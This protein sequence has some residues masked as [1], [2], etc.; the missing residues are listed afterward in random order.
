MRKLAVKL[1]FFVFIVPTYASEAFDDCLL[2]KIKDL[3]NNQTKEEIRTECNRLVKVEAESKQTPE[4]QVVVTTNAISK[5]IKREVEAENNR[6]MITAHKE[7]VN[8]S[9]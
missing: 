4:Q 9:V 5:R 3:N 8:I 2:T 7:D 1:A 6:Y